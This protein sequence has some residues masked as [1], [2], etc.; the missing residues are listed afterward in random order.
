[1]TKFLSTCIVPARLCLHRAR[2]PQ[3]PSTRRAPAPS[4][5]RPHRA[6]RIHR[7]VGPPARCAPR[8]R[9]VVFTRGRADQTQMLDPTPPRRCAA[10][11]YLASRPR[12][13]HSR[14]ARPYATAAD[15]RCAQ[16]GATDRAETASSARRGARAQDRRRDHQFQ[17]LAAPT[18]KDRRREFGVRQRLT[19]SQTCAI[20]RLHRLVPTYW[21]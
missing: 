4:T 13:P 18:R 1:M 16:T 10:E 12:G 3:S 19:S 9:A 5:C 2:C 15:R 6:R 17:V 21:D 14:R 20:T 7:R 8:H 11:L